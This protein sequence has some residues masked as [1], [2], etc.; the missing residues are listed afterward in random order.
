MPQQL[1]GW[2]LWP[3]NLPSWLISKWDS[4]CRKARQQDFS[5]KVPIKTSSSNH[6]LL[7]AR[8]VNLRKKSW[9][10]QKKEISARFSP[11]NLNKSTENETGIHQFTSELIIIWGFP[12]IEVPPSYHSFQI[13]ICPYKPSISG[14]PDLWKPLFLLFYGLVIHFGEPWSFQ[15][16]RIGFGMCG[17]DDQG[18][19]TATR[20][21]NMF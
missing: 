15:I 10:V 2:K 5:T 3:S 9:A 7:L 4:S 20:A 6:P 21:F 13:G 11:C 17:T 18:S 12:K 19:K 1:S 16:A 14:Y 8:Q